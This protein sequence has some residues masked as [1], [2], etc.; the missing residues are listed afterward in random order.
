MWG[1]SFTLRLFYLLGVSILA[2]KIEKEMNLV[3][4]LAE[5][6]NRIIVT[7]IFF[8]IFFIIGFIYIKDI[9]GFIEAD[10]DFKLTVT[11]IADIIW[12][13]I[14]IAGIL[15]IVGTLP[16]LS[17]QLWMFIKPGLKKHER[18]TSLAYVPAVFILFIMGLV[19]GYLLFTNLIVPFLLSLND[20]MFNEL[21][22]VDKYFKFMFKV[23]I[24]FALLFEIP[25]VA[26]FLTSLGIISPQFLRKSRKYAYLILLI[27]GALITPP[28]IF[29]QLIV[30]IPLF[31][32]YEISIYLSVIV[33]RRKAK[34]HKE[35]MES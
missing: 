1:A 3:G 25:I 2:K 33:E 11:G 23:L 14:S 19:F 10:I 4:H 31:I 5:L 30:A 22:T 24:P 35:F 17:L 9:Y 29:L 28:D 21:F 20:G 13:Y 16:I 6:R 8:V 32:L 18:K 12:I 7:L 15:A 26:M 27:L 34:K